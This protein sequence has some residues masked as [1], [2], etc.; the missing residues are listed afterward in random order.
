M[1]T[2]ARR[3][4]TETIVIA[5]VIVVGFSRIVAHDWTHFDDPIH[6]TE[7]TA[8][9]S[10]SW[11]HLADFWVRSYGQLYVPVSD[12]IF[13]AE[14]VASRWLHG[15]GPMTVPRPGFFHAVSL[16]LHIAAA[17][18]VH[19]ILRR[20]TTQPWAAVAG[21]LVFAEHRAVRCL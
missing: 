14:C 3:S 16:A 17:M 19:R 15:D 13:A 5:A 10:V 9:F 20:F 8:F 2:R 18:L 6:V 12:T 11:P 4:I 21:S 7:N 1:N